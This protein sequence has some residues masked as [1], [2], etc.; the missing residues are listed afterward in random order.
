MDAITLHFPVLDSSLNCQITSLSWV[1]S[2]S[3]LV[4]QVHMNPSQSTLSIEGDDIDR[5]DKAMQHISYLNSRQ[6]PTPGIRRLKITSTVKYV[7][8]L[9]WGIPV[10]G[11]GIMDISLVETK[12]SW[13][14]PASHIA[15]MLELER[16]PQQHSACCLRME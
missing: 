1:F 5:V 7:L 14:V 12:E 11:W 13:P 15:S 6:F 2:Y 4:S 9:T 10:Q 8:V 16:F 3:F